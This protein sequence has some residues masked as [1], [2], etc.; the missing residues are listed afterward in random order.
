MKLSFLIKLVLSLLLLICLYMIF[1]KPLNSRIKLILIIFSVVIGIYLFNSL[2]LF[3]DYNV[4]LESPQNARNQYIIENSELKNSEG[5]FGISSWIFIDDWNY[6]YG[7]EK[8]ILKKDTVNEELPYIGLD[9][10][11]N[12]LIIRMN[13]FEVS[14]DLYPE[15]LKDIVAIYDDD[16]QEPSGAVYSCSGEE[17]VVTD[18]NNNVSYTGYQCKPIDKLIGNIKIE[19]INL[20][21]WV[22]IIV[23]INNRS[24]DIYM[25]G[26]LVKTH[27]FNNVIDT[28]KINEG[29]ILVTPDGGFSGFVSK[30]QYFPYHVSPERAWDIYK[31]GYGD[32]VETALNKYNM[33]INFYKDSIEQE[34]YFLF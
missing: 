28:T 2:N 29:N 21:K 6:K 7:S 25:N 17:I 23:T 27:T 18:I 9:R 16:Y 33:S 20:Q 34:K 11:K 32:A 10:Y 26:K 12:D 8:T 15:L 24:V 5:H 3:K 30:I 31:S 22:N 4:F 13:V 1:A 19:N 14:N